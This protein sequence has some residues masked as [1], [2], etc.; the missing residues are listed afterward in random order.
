M[1]LEELASNS[2]APEHDDVPPKIAVTEPTSTLLETYRENIVDNTEEEMQALLTSC[3]GNHFWTVEEKQCLVFFCDLVDGDFDV[4]HE[5]YFTHRTI[6]SLRS[7]W[8]SLQRGQE[9]PMTTPRLSLSNALVKASNAVI[10]VCTPNASPGRVLQPVVEEVDEDEEDAEFLEAIKQAGLGKE[11]ENEVQK[12]TVPE[13][14]EL[15]EG[16]V[17]TEE[18]EQTEIEQTEN[19]EESDNLV[20]WALLPFILVLIITFA[21]FVVPQNSLPNDLITY[22]TNLEMWSQRIVEELYGLL[23]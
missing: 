2:E 14:E 12:E 17:E 20:F 9:T 5:V 22:K 8:H 11:E 10:K 19:V 15:P 3:Y 6:G 4:L 13:N 16:A 18:V 7:R 21:I 23:G 1:V